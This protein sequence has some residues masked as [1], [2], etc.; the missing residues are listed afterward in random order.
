MLNSNISFWGH[1]SNHNTTNG[2]GGCLRGEEARREDSSG[3]GKGYRSVGH[4]KEWKTGS[5]H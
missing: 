4:S 5:L 2:R 3:I 1:N